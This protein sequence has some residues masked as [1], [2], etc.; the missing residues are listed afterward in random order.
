MALVTPPS[1]VNKPCVAG[2]ETSSAAQVSAG[3][4]EHRTQG[5]EEEEEGRAMEATK[6]MWDASAAG[7]LHLTLLHEAL[8]AGARVDWRDAEDRGN[9]A[10]H[11]AAEMGALALVLVLLKSEGCWGRGAA[12]SSR[13]AFNDTPLH[14]AAFKGHPA[15]VK[16]LIEAQVT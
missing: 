7:D 4:G 6:K 1:L 12:P 13:N 14:A 15:V 11:K 2:A 3:Q 8:A 16:V 10:L 9:C 5:S